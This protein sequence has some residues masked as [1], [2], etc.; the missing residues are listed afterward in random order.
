MPVIPAWILAFLEPI[1]QWLFTNVEHA[2]VAAFNDWVQQKKTE[3]AA[4]DALA[5]YLAAKGT[6]NAQNSFDNLITTLKH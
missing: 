3:K 4:H 5:A 2:I 1:A 6:A